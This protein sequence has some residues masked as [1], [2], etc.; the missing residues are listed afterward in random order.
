MNSQTERFR[1]AAI[2]V[3]SLDETAATA[4]YESFSE[5]DAQR[6]RQAVEDLADIDIEEQQAVLAEFLDDR[7]S[8]VEE[9]G[10][11]LDD[12]LARRLAGLECLAP[13][14]PVAASAPRPTGL[15]ELTDINTE[16]LVRCLV[17]EHPQT[18]AV[19]LA[20]LTPT[21]AAEVLRHWDAETRHA[22][23]DRIATLSPTP[24]ELLRE[25][26]HELL[27]RIRAAAET[28]AAARRNEAR[29]EAILAAAEEPVRLAWHGRRESMSPTSELGVAGPEQDEIELETVE[30]TAS[31]ASTGAPPSVEREIATLDDAAADHVATR[32]SGHDERGASP[33]AWEDLGRFDDESLALLYASAPAEV[34]R[35]ALAGAD[36]GMIQ[37]MRR[38]LGHRAARLL[39]RQL[40]RL[41]AVRISDIVEAQQRLGELAGR[42]V[43]EGVL[44]AI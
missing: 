36:V 11:E 30:R 10:V 25:I 39:D 26:E 2:L 34:V 32:F 19:V 35:L 14:K 7:A 24:P 4:L 17:D 31:V 20:Q 9:V 15:C 1:K 5:E 29:V 37:R 16:S 3:A 21:R 43:S 42:L 13:T 27:V 33:L 28:S 8:R 38:H 23:L 18:V 12:N 22:L 40:H 6:L 41:D 44:G